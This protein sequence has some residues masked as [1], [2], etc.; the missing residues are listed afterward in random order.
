VKPDAAPRPAPAAS[1]VALPASLAGSRA[2]RLPL[3]PD[4]H[5]AKAH[6]VRDF[7]DYFLLAQH[8]LTPAA[9]DALVA[10]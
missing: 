2:P 9:L 3:G 6:A 10:R 5:L 7:F 8:D 4:G 1:D